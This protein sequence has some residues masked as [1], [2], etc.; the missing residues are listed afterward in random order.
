MLTSKVTEFHLMPACMMN[1]HDG[2]AFRYTNEDGI[3]YECICHCHY[4][5]D[6][7]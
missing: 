6:A 3:R 1:D 4:G 7:K 5:S 2:C